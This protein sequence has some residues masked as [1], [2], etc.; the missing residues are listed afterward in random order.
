MAGNDVMMSLSSSA[1]VPCWL[2]ARPFLLA[3]TLRWLNIQRRYRLLL[4]ASV[5]LLIVAAGVL[6]LPVVGHVLEAAAQ[7]PLTPF[8][9]L[10]AV[11]AIATAQRKARIG[12]SFVDSWLAPLA[13][14]SS[15]ALRMLLPAL[16]QVLFLGLAIAVPLVAGRLSWSGAVV[17]WLTVGAA[18]GIGSLIGWF[19][20]GASRT[21]APA[22]H[23]VSVRK[24]R[25]NW[26][27]AP[28]LEPLSYW[29]MGQ[30]RAIANPKAAANALLLVLLALPMGTPGQEAVAIAAGAWVLLFVVSLLV[31]TVRVAFNA[32]RWLAITNIRYFKLSMAIGYRVLLAQVWIWGWVVFLSYAAALRGALRIGLPLLLLFLFLTCAVTLVASWAAMKAVGMRSS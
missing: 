28:R 10:G 30:A 2:R 7:F 20:Q 13:A 21:A 29:A 16:V 9:S 17:L 23:Y 32:A 5:V 31:A 3:G 24:P 18:Y 12:R 11:C 22:F 6:T 26:S 27:Q 1:G 14:P 4:P 15:F 19:S 8:A 25:E